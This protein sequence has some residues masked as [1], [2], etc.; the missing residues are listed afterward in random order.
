MGYAI[1][2]GASAALL[3]GLFYWSTAGFMRQQSDATI[4]AE[5]AG[6]AERY[7]VEGLD[8]LTAAIEE[9]LLRAPST[10]SIY[11]FA[12]PGHQRIVGN[13]T[14]WPEGTPDAGGWVDF[15]LTDPSGEADEARGG[16]PRA[17]RARTFRLAEGYSLLVGRDMQELD[18]L[19]ARTVRTLTWGV[20][21]TALLAL[22]GGALVSYSTGRR[23]STINAA[24]D[25][26]MS[27]ELSR[28]LPTRGVGDELDLLAGNVNRMLT[29]IERAM[30]DVRRVSD[31]VAHDLRTPLTRLRNRLETLRAETGPGTEE[32]VVSAI[33]EADGLLQ[34]FNALLRI[35][36]VE[37]RQRTDGFS[38]VDLQSI[39]TDAAELYGPV[40][41]ARGQHLEVAIAPVPALVGDADL[42]F[43]ALVNLLD[44]AVKYGPEGGDV[45]LSLSAVGSTA[46]I[47]VEDNGPG[48]AEELRDDALRRF[49]R[50]DH[51]RTSPGSGLGLS[52]VEAVAN[53]HAADLALE[54]AGPGLRVVLRLPIQ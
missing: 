25:E 27:G 49:W 18:A 20:G 19:Q 14:G 40:A 2:F 38:E 34:T 15:R 47:A 7:R 33:Q 43:Q 42:L 51:S 3:F 39:V 11:L 46:T 23:L 30:D 13:L 9:R 24:I 26:I 1:L 28:R 32:A 17:A 16:E 31:N 36:R 52:L 35:A 12:G 54:D 53:L 48:I 5:A 10:A 37:A 21:L 50:G 45:R 44:N 29:S 8:G 22:A 4:Q 6:L 41:E